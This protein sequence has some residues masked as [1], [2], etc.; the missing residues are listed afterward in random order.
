MKKITLKLTEAEYKI[1]DSLIN[2]DNYT[3][4]GLS[5]SLL[6]GLLQNEKN[7]LS[8]YNVDK[9]R[10][11]LNDEIDK[12]HQSDL[13]NYGHRNCAYEFKVDETKMF[14]KL[15]NFKSILS[16]LDDATRTITLKLTPDNNRNIEECLKDSKWSTLCAVLHQA[17]LK[18]KDV[19]IEVLD[20]TSVGGGFTCDV[21]DVDKFREFLIDEC[22]KCFKAIHLDESECPF[23]SQSKYY[24]GSESQKHNNLKSILSK[25]DDAVNKPEEGKIYAL[26]GGFG[27]KCIANGDSWKDS[28]VQND[29]PKGNIGVWDIKFYK[30]DDEGNQTLYE[31]NGDCSVFSDMVDEN[32]LTKIK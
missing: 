26:T 13:Y 18:P 16:K 23:P 31:Y 11:F 14:K 6:G 8:V 7:T 17:N 3:T 28:V 9:F 24:E 21:L 12:I 25:L 22:G 1:I 27:D 10:E 19:G 2:D 4:C 32:D 30:E 5:I 20:S 29:E 15:D